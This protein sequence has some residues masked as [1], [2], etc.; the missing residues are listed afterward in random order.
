[1][2]IL[3]CPSLQ[4]PRGADSCDDSTAPNQFPYIHRLHP[5]GADR[6]QTEFRVL[7]SP[8]EL[9]RN[10]DAAR[11]FEENV[12]RRLLACDVLAGHDGVEQFYDAEVFE[13]LRDDFFRAARSD[14]QGNLSVMLA[15]D[16]DDRVDRF[17]LM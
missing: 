7:V 13:H 10:S 6:L 16:A 3:F 12:R 14:R 9:R 8:A 4:F 5:G 17:H 15:R 2:A 11:G 1:M